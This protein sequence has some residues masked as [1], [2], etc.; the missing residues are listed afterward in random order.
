MHVA[1]LR[2]IVGA[3]RQQRQFRREAP[4]N[5]TE[6]IEVGGVSGVVNGVLAAAQYVSAIA[7]VRIFQ[8]ARAP[9]PR[10]NM[11][12]QKIAVAGI[13]PPVQLNDL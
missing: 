2:R 13:L 11:R 8:N 5:F 3:D 1:K 4:S 9:M 7:A 10:G 6:A 12:Y